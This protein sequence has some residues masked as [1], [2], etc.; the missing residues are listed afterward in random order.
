MIVII[1]IGI[2]NIGSIKNAL[3]YLKIKNKTSRS[4]IDLVNAKK[5]IFPGNGNF[6][7]A[8]KLIKKYSLDKIL[9]EEI[10]NKKKPFLGICLGYQI[11]LNKSEESKNIDGLGWINGKVKRF[12][13]T[14]KFK[15]PH[16]EQY[17]Y[18]S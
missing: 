15:V 12:K 6:G 7:E 16:V 2:S 3:D 17:H 11:M 1:D 9:Y 8:M 5:V 14:K 13:K 4:E 10:I 18:R